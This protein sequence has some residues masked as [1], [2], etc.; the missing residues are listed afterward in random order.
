MARSKKSVLWAAGVAGVTAVAV[1]ATVVTF[2]VLGINRAGEFEQ[3][4]EG[5]C[6]PLVVLAFRGSGEQNL[7]AG[8]HN[9]AGAPFRYSD[10]E[11]VT[12]G[13]EGITLDG[14]FE[15]L[16]QTEYN[17]LKGDTIPVV[18]IGPASVDEP[19]GYDAI[20]AVL[21]ASSVGSALS[22]ANSK[23]LHSATR[24]AEAATH[25]IQD[26]LT[27][28]EGCPVTPKFVVTGYSQ[29]AMAARHTAELNPESVLAVLK[30][31]DPYQMP[32]GLGVRAE[33]AS[34]IGIIRWKAD[35]AQQ[36]L[37]DAYYDA[38]DTTS[39]VCHAGDPICEFSPIEGLLK[40]AT[41]NYGDHMDYYTDIYPGEAE[42]DALTIARL[43]YEQRMLALAA[44]EAGETVSFEEANPDAVQLRSVSLSYAGTPTLF[45]VWHPGMI[46]ADLRFEFDIDGDGVY[47]TKSENGIVWATFDDAGTQ[48]VGVRVTDPTTGEVSE[49]TT[50]IVAAPEADG[51]I[52]L[53]AGPVV[54]DPVEAEPA[55]TSPAPSVVY[56]P[57]PLARPTIPVTSPAQPAQPAPAPAPAPALP[58]VEEEDAG[59]GDAR[60]ELPEQEIEP[61]PEPQPEP[62]PE[63]EPQPEPGP[64]IVLGNPEVSAGEGL[65]IT[66]TGFNPNSYVFIDSFDFNASPGEAYVGDDGAFSADFWIPDD[67]PSGEYR[68][69]VREFDP[70]AGT[71]GREY[72]ET[73][74]V[75]GSQSPGNG[76]QPHEEPPFASAS[77]QNPEVRAGDALII[78]GT[79]FEPF[80]T[81]DISS[82]GFRGTVLIVHTDATGSFVAQYSIDSEM[83]PG[84]YAVQVTGTPQN[85]DS[86][87]QFEETFSVTPDL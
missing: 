6:A 1:L 19:F 48:T 55:A 5:E 15:T 20:S 71:F 79:G 66:G 80:T 3:A 62:E 25:L 40:L 68:I 75:V 18:P 74:T 56:S 81:V 78:T 22:F 63:P 39:S 10:S 73:F 7:T 36:Q 21:E 69:Q 24:G 77:I 37:L 60:E 59:E 45:S 23:L 46:G 47:E 9:S 61:E 4:I 82:V 34:G 8:V 28:S 67:V 53:D 17:D 70:E 14:L 41:G 16:S 83:S 12:N 2:S 44:A 42:E 51:E 11:L 30:I 85:A 49:S 27:K 31:G 72:F 84:D 33:G 52:L 50:R 29:G 57:A 13:W 35:S 65:V 54:T 38:F 58:P 64:V 32:D 76:E 87:A 86:S 26:Y 43:A